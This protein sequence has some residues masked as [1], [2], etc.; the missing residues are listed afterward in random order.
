MAIPKVGFD[1]NRTNQ[2]ELEI[3]SLQSLSGRTM[4]RHDPQLPHRIR[5]FQLLLIEQGQGRHM[6]DFQEYPVSPGSVVFVQ[7]GQVQAFR[8][9]AELKGKLLL[10]TQG[11]L[12]KLHNQMRLTSFTPT[13]LNQH[14]HPL[15]QLDADNL[16]RCRALTGEMAA[17][18]ALERPD[19]LMVMH[20]FSALNLLLHRLKP[21]QR[22]ERLPDEQRA[23]LGRFIGLLEN[24][25]HQT[26]DANW[27]ASQIGITY[28]TL[29]CLCKAAMEMTA[30]Q[31]IDAYAILEI[32][33]R[34]V[35]SQ[36]T[37]SQ[38]ALDLGFEDASN[39]VK[40]FKKQVGMTPSQ[41][42]HSFIT[43]TL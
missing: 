33:R 39:F 24:H 22:Q 14:H 9:S 34:L 15:T 7:P 31:A 1:L 40:Y 38:M 19:S 11:F 42:R 43:P 25:F 2:A 18:T 6:V 28:K 35:V 12:D 37:S 29:N 32:K 8:F 16:A 3:L 10:F 36:D 20:L 17:E 13:H 21:Q 4:K 5:F 26:R 23:R 30:K 41:F 27:Y